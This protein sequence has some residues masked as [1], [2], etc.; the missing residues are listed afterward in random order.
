MSAPL[1]LSDLPSV[2][3]YAST[4]DALRA[5]VIAAKKARQVRI[6][7]NATLLFEN[8]DT[9]KYQI[10]EMLRIE[11]TSDPAAIQDELDAYN[12]LIPAGSD[13]TAAFRAAAS[14][15]WTWTRGPSPGIAP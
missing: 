9:V 5:N 15:G 8:R 14:A 13:C 6:G 1:Q 4:R 12:P 7:E 2:E 11:K 10:L 3:E